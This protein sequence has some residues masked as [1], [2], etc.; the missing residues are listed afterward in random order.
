MADETPTTD[1]AEQ[2]G[3]AEA[4]TEPAEATQTREPAVSSEV[5]QTG[6]CVRLVK[7]RIPAEIVQQEIDSSYDEL[8]KTVFIKGFRRGRVPRHILERRF[9]EDVRESVKQSLV[10]GKFDEVIEKH[11]LRLVSTPRINLD[12]IALQPGQPL[13]FEV[14]V[15]VSPEFTI[16]NYTGLEVQRPETTVTD[17]DVERALEAFRM[18]HAEYRKIEEGTVQEEDVPICHAIALKDGQEVWRREELGVD[19][20]AETIGGLRIEGIKDALLGAAPGDTRLFENITLPDNFTE[21]TLRGQSVNIQVTIDEIRRFTPP[22]ATDEW[23]R[24]LHFDDLDDLR[25]ELLDQLRL[26]RERQADQAV[27]ERIEDRLLELTDFEVPESLV[28]R[29]VNQAVE[30]NRM[31]LLYQGV[32]EDRIEEI[33]AT[34]AK[35]ARQS[36][37]RQCKLFFILEK[38]ADQ[39]KIFV[40]EDELDQRI[41][42]IALNYRRRPQDVRADLEEAGRL[43]ALRR[44]MR[45][46]KVFDF[47]TRNARIIEPTSPQP[48]H[49]TQPHPPQ[50]DAS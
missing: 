36:S 39:E 47:L 29:M 40:T 43:D 13:T 5:E 10:E 20:R 15:E 49:D 14:S 12:E 26:E 16:D 48:D 32:A 30:R 7:V 41:Q 45:E 19:L 2:S 11:N 35:N 38:I 9:S 3:G 44:Q 50:D 21:E 4:T 25:E 27:R 8:R 42:A 31:A 37:V 22:E 46:E 17:E 18:R 34:Y 1:P 24:S 6:P 28:E 33:L 23:A